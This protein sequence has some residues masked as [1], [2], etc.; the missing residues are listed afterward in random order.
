MGRLS[1]DKLKDFFFGKPEELETPE[2]D[3]INADDTD[4]QAL[5]VPYTNRHP[6]GRLFAF[7]KP[8]TGTPGADSQ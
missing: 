8:H 4:E 5:A 2:L 1:F 7:A 6:L 3:N